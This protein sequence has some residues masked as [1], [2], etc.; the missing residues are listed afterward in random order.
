[1]SPRVFQSSREK[2][3]ST[4]A[5]RSQIGGQLRARYELDLAKPLPVRL[6]ELLRRLGDRDDKPKSANRA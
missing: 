1:M 6:L 4:R 3:S 5:I 2:T